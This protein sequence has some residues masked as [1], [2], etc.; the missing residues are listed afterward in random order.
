MSQGVSGFV[1]LPVTAYLFAPFGA[2]PPKAGAIL[3]TLAGV[4]LVIAAWSLCAT[5]AG[6]DRVA[7]WR[8]ALLFA[9]SGPLQY[10]VREGNTSHMVLF[11][12]AAG[13][14]L[15]RSG[16]GVPA[17]VV[18]GAAAVLK[19]PLALMGLFFLA[20]RDLRGLAAFV[21]T[22]LLAVLASLV[23]FGWRENLHWFDT[24]ILQFNR[25]WLAAFNVQSIAA[26]LLR[27]VSAP[28]RLLDWNPFP[29]PAWARLTSQLLTAG[30]LATAAAVLLPRRRKGASRA[31]PSDQPLELQFLLAVCLCVVASP[32]TW[33][34]Y[35]AWLLL[36]VAFLLRA[37]S[38]LAWAAIL[39]LTP[40]VWPLGPADPTAA[41]AYRLAWVNHLLLGGLLA[42][43]LIAWRL[44]QI[45][46][47]VQLPAWS[48]R[49]APS[50]APNEMAAGSGAA[51]H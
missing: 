21:A 30:L 20:R 19:P 37:P 27:F 4:G 2:L 29:P 3:F 12:L 23:V 7:R 14:W 13:L 8:L 38:P 32:L 50:T 1:N 24:S 11:A 42:F 5:L 44:A 41:A 22:G 35:Y 47:L 6:L 36:P 25:E 31:D 49:P 17:A 43:G 26:F 51:D 10:S 45:Q 33:S 40:L 46:G 9:A 34:H 48:A 15:A 28:E 39:L 18:L 16:R